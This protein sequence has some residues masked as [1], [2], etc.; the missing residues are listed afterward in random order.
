MLPILF[1][2]MLATPMALQWAERIR[3]TRP[4][5]PRP[6]DIGVIFSWVVFMYGGLPV[7]GFFLAA[8]GIGSIQEG[9]LGGDLPA[10]AQIF[11]VG[12]MYCLFNAGFAFAYSATRR[13]AKIWQPTSL[14]AASSRDVLMALSIFA[15][16]KVSML[17]MRLALGIETEDDYLATYTEWAGQPLIV[18]QVAGILAA[19]ELAVTML[20]IVTVISKRPKLHVYVAGFVVAQILATVVIGGSR[21]QAFA[22][23]L[24][25]IV[26][27]SL[28]DYRLRFG[29]ILWAGLVGLLLFLVAGALRQLNVGTEDISGLYLLQGG[30][31][32]SVFTNALDLQERLTDFDGTFLRAGMY[33]VDLLRFIP[34]QFIGDFKIDP[35]TLYV[36]TFYPEASEA[37]AG[38]AFG[39]IA[40]STI[41][42][43]PA[44]ALVRGLLLGLLYAWVRN[45]CLTRQ[46]SVVRAF[47]YTWFVVLAYQGIR[48]TTFTVFPRFFFQVSPILAVLWM[49][50]AFQMRRRG[51]KRQPGVQAP[52]VVVP[53]LTIKAPDSAAL[54]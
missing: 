40:E 42:F 7:L 31:F 6:L 43:G 45:A 35:A 19:S 21:T 15:F 22:C 3:Y 54:R 16:T 38:L 51:R 2:A 14:A 26:A 13:R 30:E 23:A 20:V 49:L 1:I 25:Y 9:R 47:V 34:R 39:A 28:Y 44:E 4:R 37:G 17:A 33:L 36:A 27:R 29:T 8:Q 52:V 12:L 41:G 50:G 18:Q 24:A 5:L 46:L 53:P 10:Q 32:M 48:D 11:Q